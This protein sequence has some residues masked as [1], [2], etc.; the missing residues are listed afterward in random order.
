MERKSYVPIFAG[1][2][3]TAVEAEC[4]SLADTDAML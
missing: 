2:D 4:D 3:A 1:V